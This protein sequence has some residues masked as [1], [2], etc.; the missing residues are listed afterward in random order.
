MAYGT[1]TPFE[2]KARLDS[3]E[4]IQIIDIREPHER[5]IAKF[6]EAKPMPIGQIAR[7]CDEL[8]P[9]LDTVFICKIGTRSIFAINALFE[10]GYSGK[11]YNLQ[12]GINGW[13][14]DI[15]NSLPRY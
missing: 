1:L 10:T 9:E 5:A 13:A 14:R 11:V 12:D 4:K 15:D 7:R 3:G 2:L 8:D 6:P